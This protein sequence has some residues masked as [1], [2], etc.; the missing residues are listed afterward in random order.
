MTS[1]TKA[2]LPDIGLDASADPFTR[3]FFDQTGSYPAA[4]K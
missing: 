2:A 1:V 3:A 4:V